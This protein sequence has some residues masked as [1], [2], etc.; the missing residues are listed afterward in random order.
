MNIEKRNFN[1]KVITRLQ[2][3]DNTILDNPNDILKEE[4]RFYEKLYTDSGNNDEPDINFFDPDPSIPKLTEEENLSLQTLI[5]EKEIL[6][7]LKCTKNNKFPG[8]DGFPAEFYKFFWND[9][10]EY[11]MDSYKYA[12]DYGKLS[13][14]QREGIICVIPKKSKDI[15]RLRNWRPLSILNQDYKIL[16]KALALRFQNVIEKIINKDQTGFIQNKFRDENVAKTPSIIDH[17][18]K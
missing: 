10:K 1:N 4:K 6:Y 16:S 17:C 14:T 2:L 5:T 18:K 7:A 15:L 9:L 8:L 11:L 12:Y 13:I 3:D